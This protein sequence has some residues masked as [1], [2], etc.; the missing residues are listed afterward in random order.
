MRI[1][2]P[3]R[4]APSKA[5]IFAVLSFVAQQVEHTD[6][7]FSAL[8]AAFVVLSVFA[9]NKAGGFTRFAGA[10][11]AFFSLLVCIIGVSWKIVINEPGQSNLQAPTLTMLC[12][13]ASAAMFLV[14]AF[15]LENVDLRSYEFGSGGL[16]RSLNYTAAGLG[17]ILVSLAN[18]AAGALFGVNPGG[19]LS[20]LHQLD[21]FLPLGTL[22]ATIGAINDSKGK[23][24]V[25]FVS[26][27]GMLYMFSGGLTAFS[28]QGMLSPMVCWLLAVIYKQVDLRRSHL[29]AI[30]IGTYMAFFVF[31]PLSLSRDLITPDMTYTDRLVLG[32]DSI[33][34]IQRIRDHVKTYGDT[35]PAHSYFNTAQNALVQRLTMMGTD[36][37]LISLAATA[38]PLGW[39]PVVDDFMNFI[40]HALAPNKRTV[41]TGNYYGHEIGG[42]LA[43]D[44]FGTGISFSPVSEAFRIQR[45][46]GLFVILPGVWL[47]LFPLVEFICGD[48]KTSP[49]TLMPMLAAA[50]IAP[51]GLLSGQIYL[52]GFGN[53]G[54]LLGILVATRLSPTLGKLFLGSGTESTG[55]EDA[56]WA[57]RRRPPAAGAQPLPALR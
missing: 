2:L 32:I 12:Y 35:P 5:I 25:N 37:A 8:Y 31:S 15:I 7:A 20:A 39:G 4:V 23:R 51:E 21:N 18:N 29:L 10:Y 57:A 19:L 38:E 47:L 42:M 49:W 22:L 1:G 16:S 41:L 28:K 36:D 30:A 50:H 24:T 27:F 6:I 26:G 14:V 34:H 9:F 53:A 48:L 11:Y 33:I 13:V 46:V 55:A 43:D 45:W 44:D 54:F 40:P 52:L 17:C 3:E 56:A